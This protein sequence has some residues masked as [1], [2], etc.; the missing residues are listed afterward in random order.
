MN[1]DRTSRSL[2]SQDQAI[3]EQAQYPPYLPPTQEYETTGALDLAALQPLQK[4]TSQVPSYSEGFRTQNQTTPLPPAAP[5]WKQPRYR[6]IAVV[7]LIISVIILSVVLLLP[8]LW[9]FSQTST[10]IPAAPPALAPVGQV[11]F[12]SSRQLSP[13]SA[14]GINDGVTVTLHALKSPAPGNAFYAWLLP[15]QTRDEMKPILL[16]RLA[17]THGVAQLTYS[18]P[19]HTD[20]LVTYSGFCI[21]EEDGSTN[22]ATPSLDQAHWR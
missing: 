14:Q 19:S 8:F 13:N 22:P 3:V 4:G 16:G 12:S 11:V 2:S 15:D 6:S 17:L 10:L 7:V 5:I 20:L 1:R 21:T 9:T 18:D